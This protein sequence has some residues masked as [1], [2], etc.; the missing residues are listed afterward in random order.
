M[1]LS[2]SEDML[3]AGAVS[4]AD[5]RR[6]QS[7]L[8]PDFEQRNGPLNVSRW[9]CRT[10]SVTGVSGARRQKAA[11]VHA[12]ANL[13]RRMYH[14]TLTELPNYT[15]K[16]YARTTSAT[17]SSTTRH[18]EFW[19]AALFVYTPVMLPPRRPHDTWFHARPVYGF[20]H[21]DYFQAEHEDGRA[22]SER[23]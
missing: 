10:S 3:R 7:R 6:D 2:L 20:S 11:T 14:I 16:N 12:H 21:Q 4:A 22:L 13:T 23:D 1:L 15:T 9:H 18:D 17:D 8:T 5:A 19:L